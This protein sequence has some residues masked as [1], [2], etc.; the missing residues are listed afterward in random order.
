MAAEAPPFE[1]KDKDEE[2]GKMI[3]MS[4]LS[5]DSLEK[6][7]VDDGPFWR[8]TTLAAWSLV[9]NCTS[10]VT[11]DLTKIDHIS[12][13]EDGMLPVD[14]YKSL[15]HGME[16]AFMDHPSLTE[17]ML[18]SLARAHWSTW[19]PKLV[20]VLESGIKTRIRHLSVVGSNAFE[21]RYRDKDKVLPSFGLVKSDKEVVLWGRVLEAIS[22]ICKLESL[23]MRGIHVNWPC[24][25]SF[26]AFIRRLTK[27]THLQLCDFGLTFL[28][29]PFDALPS[30]LESINL[31]GNLFGNG[32]T[33]PRTLRETSIWSDDE[34]ESA[35]GIQTNKINAWHGLDYYVPFPFN[36]QRFPMMHSLS[37]SSCEL[38]DWTVL[39]LMRSFSSSSSSSSSSSGLL[40]LDLSH[41]PLVTAVGWAGLLHALP[42]VCPALTNLSLAETAFST[43]IAPSLSFMLMHQPRL[44]HLNLAVACPAWE[45]TCEGDADDKLPVTTWMRPVLRTLQSPFIKLESLKCNL[46]LMHQPSA[47]ALIKTLQQNQH[48]TQVVCYL[49]YG[50]TG[51]S[52]LKSGMD[53]RV[54]E[55]LIKLLQCNPNLSCLKTEYDIGSIYKRAELVAAIERHPNLVS[56]LGNTIHLG[57]PA[58]ITPLK[59]NAKRAI[60]WSL[61]API[62]VF[63]RA[64]LDINASIQDMLPVVCRHL[65]HEFAVQTLVTFIN[66]VESLFVVQQQRSATV[67][68]IAITTNTATTNTSIA[69]TFSLRAHSSSSSIITTNLTTQ[70]ESKFM[71]PRTSRKRRLDPPNGTP[72]KT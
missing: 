66:R 57:D 24:K 63:R 11:C 65:G 42:A 70:I 36:P 6:L 21:E 12:E 49:A 43:K 16:V 55:E 7:V 62:I 17:L 37:L 22:G 19:V 61:C 26:G 48:L 9:R 23:C 33:N 32:D 54:V 45:V 68:P 53:P 1:R 27:L 64:N 3:W 67:A 51:V 52:D 2:D 18:P 15:L 4:R 35:K 25:P 28:D 30:G 40:S 39:E 58:V 14:V 8:T 72:L 20:Q 69:N 46:D 71:E 44:I 60:L 5:K 34:D 56:F 38:N 41:N 29:C 13:D 10:L 47:L 50:G 59:R 31:S